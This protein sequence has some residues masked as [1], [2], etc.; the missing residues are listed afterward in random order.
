MDRVITRSI[1][2]E[3]GI[4][5]ITARGRWSA[6]DVE[7]HYS[8]LRM[9]I[10]PIRDAGEIVRIL[11]DVRQAERQTAEIEEQ[12]LREMQRTYA[13]GDRIA[14]LTADADAQ[15]HLRHLL[16]HI[17]VSAFQ[18]QLPAEMWLATDTLAKIR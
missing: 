10:Q 3:S 8:A 17:D 13:A 16:R 6:A 4:I 5:V 12:I 14:I 9:L 2:G 1:E 18:S 11:S 15:V 7:A